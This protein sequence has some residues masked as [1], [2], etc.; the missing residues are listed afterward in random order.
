MDRPTAWLWVR[1]LR[2]RAVDAGLRP[3]QTADILGAVWGLV[4]T[5]NTLGLVEWTLP[6]EER[7]GLRVGG[8]RD[9]RGP[10]MDG[11]RRMLAQVDDTPKGKRD[12]AI[13][14]LLGPGRALRRFEVVGLDVEHVD[15][16]GRRLCVLG[17]KR[18]GREWLTIGAQ[19]MDAVA[20]WIEARGDHAGP[21]FSSLDRARKG[22]GR[23][24]EVAV[25]QIVQGLGYLAGLGAVRP[26]GLRHMAATELL[27]DGVPLVQVQRFCRHADPKT[28][29]VYLDALEDWGG[30]AA[31]RL[32]AKV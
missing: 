27:R 17:K 2:Q 6:K 5:A 31:A 29:L 10:G 21:L 16:A 1:G 32:C 18:Q 26:H 25:W 9:T 30:D 19:A 8:Y 11:F 28:T 15:V 20:R 7:R 14:W 24:S 22:S 4:A 13:L 3:G 23:L 12:A